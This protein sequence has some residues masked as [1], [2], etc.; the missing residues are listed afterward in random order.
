MEVKEL[1][2]KFKSLIAERDL[3]IDFGDEGY[4]ARCQEIDDQLIPEIIKQVPPELMHGFNELINNEGLLEA[5]L[6]MKHHKLESV[7]KLTLN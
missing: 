4:N 3:I 6:A 1:A 2:K 5:L 7:K